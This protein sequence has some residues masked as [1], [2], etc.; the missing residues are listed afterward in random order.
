MG[1]EPTTFCMA[2]RRSS[3]LS[4]SRAKEDSSPR[5]SASR[6]EGLVDERV[7]R[8]VLLAPHVADRPAVE[9]VQRLADRGVERAQSGVLDSI[10]PQHLAHDQLRVA[11]ELQLA[12]AERPGA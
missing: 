7:G 2:S 4:Y 9:A 10:V 12:C 6:V 1:F 11:H 3:Q 8:L 5:R